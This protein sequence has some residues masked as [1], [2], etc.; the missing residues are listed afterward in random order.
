ML[1]QLA[2]LTATSLHWTSTFV[3]ESPNSNNQ[4]IFAMLAS[5]SILLSVLPLLARGD[6][7]QSASTTTHVV[8]VTRTTL[9]T[10]SA[11]SAQTPFSTIDG[12]APPPAAAQV[13]FFPQTP[14]P[15]APSATPLVMG[16]YPDWAGPAFPPEKVDFTRFDWVDFAFAIPNASFALTWDDAIGAPDLL[17]RLVGAAH[18]AGKHVKLSVGGWT[19][20]A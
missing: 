14:L 10:N 3:L 6:P 20:S 5:A 7:P 2:D 8:T 12:I 18:L 1:K 15:A 17:H 11:R 4:H 16:Y 19:G 13:Y 9:A